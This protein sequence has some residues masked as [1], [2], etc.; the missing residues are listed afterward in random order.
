MIRYSIQHAITFL[1]RLI[2]TVAIGCAFASCMF[3]TWSHA[4]PRRGN[5]LNADPKAV[6]YTKTHGFPLRTVRVMARDGVVRTRNVVPVTE[7]TELDFLS[8]FSAPN[9]FVTWRHYE[10]DPVHAILMLGERDHVGHSRRPHHD[11]FSEM[12]EGI[13]VNRP[14]R[15][16]PLRLDAKHRSYMVRRFEEVNSSRNTMF[17]MGRAREIWGDDLIET[18]GCMWWLVHSETGPGIS[19][20]TTLGVSRSKAPE[21][22]IRKIIWEGNHR[23]NTI[24][25]TISDPR[26]ANGFR[27]GRYPVNPVT[28]IDEFNALSDEQLLGV[29]FPQGGGR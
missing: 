3:V 9:G 2:A 6:D 21:N 13:N 17:D 20:A 24:G 18:A 28:T 7:A 27:Y 23:V 10:D 14:G 25:V 22:L 15:Y 8:R 1:S 4:S 26:L 12:A 29:E 11:Y 16:V 19:L 5:S